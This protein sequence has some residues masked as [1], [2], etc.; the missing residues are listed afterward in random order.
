MG[1]RWK[2]S[3]GTAQV[4]KIGFPIDAGYAAVYEEMA[5]WQEVLRSSSGDLISTPD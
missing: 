1:E 3:E 2:R 5:E 4:R